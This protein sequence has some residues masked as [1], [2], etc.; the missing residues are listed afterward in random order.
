MKKKILKEIIKNKKRK[1]EFAVITD[2]KNGD[3]FI[4]EKNKKLNKKFKKNEKSIH[5]L[6]K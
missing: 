1:I 6:L 2:L 5:Y 4:Y 3:N